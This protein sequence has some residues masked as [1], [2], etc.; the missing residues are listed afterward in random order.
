MCVD[1]ARCLRA[2]S[3][4]K[5]VAY[6]AGYV[7]LEKPE[8]AVLR[9]LAECLGSL[10]MLDIGVGG[11]RMTE[12][13]A[14]RV[15]EYK[16]ID[17]SPAMIDTCR[18]RFAGRIPPERFAVR[19]MRDLDGY[20]AHSFELVLNSYNTMDH[21]DPEERSRF[22][23]EV[24]RITA[25]GGYFCFSTHNIRSLARREPIE[26]SW[27]RPHAAVQAL[28]HRARYLKLNRG[29]LEQIPHAEYVIINNGTHDD[30][31][32]QLYYVQPEAQ[33]A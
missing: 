22:I 5:V 20:P 26:W 29:A 14:P 16:G 25:P 4:A 18:Q 27:R 33:L 23:G 13:F 10:R 21:L 11:G 9:T 15:R 28:L 12:H 3:R 19:D 17:I 1:A 2:Y 31:E 8:Q 30:F 32:L 7:A 24:R 6:Y